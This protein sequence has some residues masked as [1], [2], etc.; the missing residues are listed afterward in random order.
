MVW[1]TRVR[2]GACCPLDQV[3]CLMGPLC[4]LGSVLQGTT[5]RGQSYETGGGGGGDKGGVQRFRV[6]ELVQGPGCVQM[7]RKGLQAS[8]SQTYPPRPFAAV[9][10]NGMGL[11]ESCRLKKLWSGPAPKESWSRTAETWQ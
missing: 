5:S 4:C 9:F 2:L 7:P 8:P 6:T 1:G 3:A 10:T 11:Q